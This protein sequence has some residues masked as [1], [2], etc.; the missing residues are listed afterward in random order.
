MLQYRV[1]TRKNP[2]TKINKFYPML[3]SPVPMPMSKI[4]E[5]IEKRCTLASA[6][7]K[8]VVDALEVEVIDCL[9]QGGSVR[10]GDL[11]SFR[12][13]LRTMGADTADKVTPENV[14]STH[15]VFQPSPKIR[16]A[17]SV[18]NRALKFGKWDDTALTKP[19][20]P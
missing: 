9:Q 6:D 11:G 12:L 17:L 4:V 15:V 19:A 8:A 3:L 1:I 16:R 10:L 5:R 2:V 13:T 14:V 18:K 7:I 20:A